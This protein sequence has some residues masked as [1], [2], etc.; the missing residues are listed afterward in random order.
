MIIY[1]GSDRIIHKPEYG[2]GKPCNDYGRGFY[3]T[4][5]A[6]L[7]R[8]WSVDA[9]RDG[10]MNRYAFVP[11]GLNVLHLNDG[12]YSILHW[13]AVLLENREF[14]L[15]TPL[16][17]EAKRYLLRYFSV[18]YKDADVIIGYRADDSY[19]SFA[20]DFVNGAISVRQLEDAMYLGELGEQVVIRSKAAFDRLIFEGYEPVS[21]ENWY[22][23]RESRDTKARKAYLHSDRTGWRKG[24]LYMTRILDEEIRPDDDRI[25]RIIY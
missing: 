16:A 19:F 13:L 15:T 18:P 17:R 21:A 9:G 6:D 23:R 3:C 1:H 24:E 10:F 11:D 22:P 12:T 7:A 14:V 2:K 8:E 5:H 25:R 4:E 20:G